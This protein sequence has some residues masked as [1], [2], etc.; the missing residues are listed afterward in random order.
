MGLRQRIGICF[1]ILSCSVGNEVTLSSMLKSLL[2][3]IW[4]QFCDE[5]E[6]RHLTLFFELLLQYS[7]VFLVEFLYHI[8][9]HLI[10]FF[11]KVSSISSKGLLHSQSSVCIF[12]LSFFFFFFKFRTFFYIP[13]ILFSLRNNEVCIIKELSNSTKIV[14]IIFLWRHLDI[15]NQ[16][17]FHV[18]FSL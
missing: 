11:I 6:I 9:S 7:C 13:S 15:L 10:H 12:C 16:I 1:A 2:L 18:T 17:R 8:F 5:N 4:E 3:G 14:F